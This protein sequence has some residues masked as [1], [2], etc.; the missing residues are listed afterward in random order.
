MSGDS[1]LDALFEEVDD[2]LL[3]GE[4]ERVDEMF[5]T[6]R[7]PYKDKLLASGLLSI[8]YAAADE[9]KNRASYYDG[10]SEYLIR[11][12]GDDKLIRGLR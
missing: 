11:T 3:A 10:F 5:S 9:L 8:T 2:L 6:K 7:Y 1:E 4:F 12:E